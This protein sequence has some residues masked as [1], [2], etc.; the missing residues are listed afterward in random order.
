LRKLISP[1]EAERRLQVIFPRAA[2]DSVFSSPLAGAAVAAMIY[3]D[4][5]CI[6]TDDVKSVYWARPSTVMWLSTDVL[7]LD[8]EEKRLAW[9]EA[10]AKPKGNESVSKLQETWG[11]PFRPSY[12]DNSR[13]TLRDETLKQ[14]KEHGVVRERADLAASSSKGRWALLEHFADLFDPELVGDEFAEAAHAWQEQY[15]DPGTRLRALHARKTEKAQHAVIVNL[16]NSG[17]ETRK[18]A[19]GVSSNIIKG[20][21]EEW[22]ILRLIKPYVLAIS[23]PGDKVHLGDANILQSLGIKIDAQRVLPDVIIADIEAN[24]VTFWIIEAAATGGVV[25]AARRQLLRDWA[26]EQNIN[27]ENCSFLTAFRSRNDA[28]ARRFLKDLASETWAWFSDE[29]NH[30]LAWYLV[31]P[32]SEEI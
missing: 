22:S 28:P 3:V 9:R 14:W 12:R 16:P 15:F 11:I 31:V 4:A 6:P 21:V 26:K 19:P 30:E 2:F 13:E 29:P 27:P 1:E 18:L 24:P 25:T 32:G 8:E 10:A 17:G 7:D 5:V 23:E 20:V